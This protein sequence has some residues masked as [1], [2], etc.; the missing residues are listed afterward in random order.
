LLDL[1]RG[2]DDGER[3]APG[4]VPASL[5]PARGLA[6]ATAVEAYRD[7]VATYL[8][9]APNEDARRLLGRIRDQEKRLGALGGDLPPETV[10]SLVRACRDLTRYLNGETGAL[11]TAR[12]RLDEFD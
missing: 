8:E 6:Y 5:A 11:A 1:L 4:D 10:E 2:A 7:D 3:P 9:D 12:Q